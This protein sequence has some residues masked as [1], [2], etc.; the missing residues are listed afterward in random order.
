MIKFLS[1]LWNSFRQYFILSL[2]V[3]LSLFLLSLNDNHSIKTFRTYSFGFYAYVYSFVSAIVSPLERISE[4]E[5]LK[6]QNAKLMLQVNL[7]REYKSENEE[8]K[9]LLNIKDTLKYDF[10]AAKISS[11]FVLN[12]QSNFIINVGQNDGIEIGMPVI[13]D[14]G[15]LGIVH[16]VSGDFS[17]IRTLRNSLLKII[18]KNQRS[19]IDGILYWN[20]DDLVI[21]NIPSNYDMDTN[22][23]VITS[24]FSTIIPPSIPIGTISK[25]E[26]SVDGLFNNII[27]KPFVNFERVT[28]VFVLK[29]VQTTQKDDLELNLF[30]N[31]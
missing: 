2:I 14:K 23:V 27:I 10:I 16:S 31:R 28:N 18:V 4:A 13:N 30:R 7:L 11:K 22:D 9:A 1:R 24:D 26:K 25:S 20:G 5:Q 3:I 6:L 21:K 8:L 29:F 15:L 19:R 17:N 12:S